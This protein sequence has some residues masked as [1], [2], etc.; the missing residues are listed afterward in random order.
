[1][2]AAGGGG[3]LHSSGVLALRAQPHPVPVG[4]VLVR[5]GEV[6]G[7]IFS[8]PQF[9]PD[10][11]SKTCTADLLRTGASAT[12][13]RTGRMMNPQMMEAAQKMMA[14]MSPEDMER[15]MQVCV[16]VRVGVVC[17][18]GAATT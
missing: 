16:C 14:K 4:V 12:G 17:A 13:C 9:C 8:C 11:I 1:M 3:A 2:R 10:G 7:L 5:D 6:S 15:M 18:P